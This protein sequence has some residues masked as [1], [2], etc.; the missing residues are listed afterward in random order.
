M[1]RI[2]FC[3]ASTCDK[4]YRAA[5]CQIFGH[6]IRLTARHVT[7]ELGPQRFVCSFEGDDKGFTFHL[8]QQTLDAAILD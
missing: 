7:E 2:V 6:Q 8:L 4:T 1:F 5:R 3:S